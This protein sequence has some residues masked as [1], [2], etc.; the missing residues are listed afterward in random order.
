MSEVSVLRCVSAHLALCHLP[1]LRG[2]CIVQPVSYCTKNPVRATCRANLRELEV[3]DCSASYKD[4]RPDKLVSE[5]VVGRYTK[6]RIAGLHCEDNQSKVER[7]VYN[8][9]RTYFG[10]TGSLTKTEIHCIQAWLRGGS[11]NE[12]GKR[13]LW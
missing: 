10:T 11:K 9:R 4:R 3:E 12:R 13:F 2:I 7:A 6:Y 1:D 5:L 8:E